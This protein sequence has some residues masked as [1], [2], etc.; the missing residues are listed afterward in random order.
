MVTVG[1]FS[2]LISLF[3]TSHSFLFQFQFNYISIFMC[4][5]FAVFIVI[6]IFFGNNKLITLILMDE[7]CEKSLQEIQLGDGLNEFE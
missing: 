4:I 6:E 5:Y 3:F 1:I 7:L 2:A